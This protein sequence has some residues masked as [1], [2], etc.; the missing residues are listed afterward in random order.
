MKATTVTTSLL[1]LSPA[2]RTARQEKLD[3]LSRTEH[4]HCVMCGPSHPNGLRLKF[5]V[6]PDSAVKAMVN[7]HPTLQS[8]ANVIHGGIVSTLLDE[9]MVTCL[10]SYGLVTVTASLEVKYYAPTVPERFA[11]LRAWMESDKAYPL[12]TMRAD[13]VQDGKRVAEATAKFVIRET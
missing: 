1:A 3:Q 5:K 6:E 8:Y 10:F 2:E 13:L 4:P 9:A 12:F 11:V 7:C